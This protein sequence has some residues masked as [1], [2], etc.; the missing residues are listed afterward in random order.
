MVD[1]RITVSSVA[2]GPSAD[3]EL[4]RN[5]AKWGKGREY[6]VADAKELPQIFVK[7]AKN[8][9]TPAFD[10]KPIKP[11]VKTPGVP[12]RRRPHAHAAAA[13]VDGHGAEG[14]GARAARHDDGDP[15]LAFWPVGLGRTAVFASDVKDRW[16]ADW[17]TWRGYGPFF[18]AVVHATRAARPPA[19]ALEV[20]PGPDSRH[21]EVCRQSSVE[22]RDMNGDYRDLLQPV[23]QVRAG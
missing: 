8:A 21:G 23:V 5:I 20:V 13:R 4:L 6:Q 14:H 1:A 18:T 9:A 22:A 10:E 11:V 19:A 2:V 15:L 3:P 12:E 7:E 17:V 16:G